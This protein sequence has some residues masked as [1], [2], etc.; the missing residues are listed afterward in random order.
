MWLREIKRFFRSKSRIIGALGQ[1]LL[2]LVAFG[3]GLQ[4]VFKAAGQGNY[5]EFLAPGV[6]GMSI[7]FSSIFNGM[8]IIWDRQFGFLKETMVAPVSRVSIMF[9]RALG[10]ATTSTMQGC[11]VLLITLFIGFHPYSWALVIPTVLVM[12]LIAVLFS[13]LGIMVASLLSD[14]QG[15]QLIM[16]F[17]VMPLFFLSGA[18]FPLSEAPK[19]MQFIARFDPLSYGIDA[20]RGLLINMS[21]YG[22]TLDIVV[23]AA[24]ALLFLGLGSYFFSKIE[25]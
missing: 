24:F 16:N 1:P 9:G 6:I 14:M 4:S 7:I 11:L 20:M 2:F 17:M 13:S 10:G 22:L 15:F 18:I 25:I 12:L 8:Q 5:I 19:A 3:Y 21:G 23:L